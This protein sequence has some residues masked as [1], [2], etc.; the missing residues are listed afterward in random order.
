MLANGA[1]QGQGFVGA[2]A[3]AAGDLAPRDG[4]TFGPEHQRREPQHHPKQD[5]DP[6]GLWL[7]QVMTLAACAPGSY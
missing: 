6:G 1:A 7:A 3:A 2:G 5:R 4:V